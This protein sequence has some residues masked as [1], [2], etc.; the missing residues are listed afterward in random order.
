MTPVQRG[1][2]MATAVITT[3]ALLGFAPRARAQLAEGIAV[4]SSAPAV[5]V[6]TLGGQ[7][8]RLTPGTPQVAG[9]PMLLEFWATWCEFCERLE[10]HMKAAYARY[11]NRVQF[12]AIAVNVNQ[13]VRRVARHVRERDLAYP[14]YYDRSG[15]ATQ[16]FGVEAT[17]FVVVVNRYGKVVYTGVG[18]GQNLDAAL[19]RAL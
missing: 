13:S 3:L 16:A 7:T 4:G 6:S 1:R 14:V 17:S 10:P 5:Q 15:S 9:R 11:G 18:D 8:V 19:K 2:M 12:S